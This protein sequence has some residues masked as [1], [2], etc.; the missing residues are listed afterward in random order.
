MSVKVIGTTC[1]SFNVADDVARQ[2]VEF[3]HDKVDH[4]TSKTIKA[5]VD[6][7]ELGDILVFVSGTKSMTVIR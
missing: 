1:G 6:G 4:Y 3:P 5:M 2:P 7:E